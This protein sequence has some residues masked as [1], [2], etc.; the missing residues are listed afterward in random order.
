[1]P[2]RL[3]SIILMSTAALLL[4]GGTAQAAAPSAGSGVAAPTAAGQAGS[5]SRSEC[6]V[7]RH[8]YVRRGYTV[9]PCQYYPKTRN[10]LFFYSRLHTG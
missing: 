3:S 1:M 2:R 8:E 7:L 4:A 9:T 10:W 6:E 5:T